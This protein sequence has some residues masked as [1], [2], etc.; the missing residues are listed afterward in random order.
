MAQKRN[1]DLE[2]VY[3]RL[4]DAPAG[5]HDL[6]APRAGLPVGAPLDLAELYI[7]IGGARLFHEAIEILPPDAVE[8]VEDAPHL[9]RFATLHGDDLACDKQARI[10]Q[11]DTAIDE[12]LQVASRLD[13]WLWGQLDAQAVVV[14]GEGEFA[15]DV[16][17]AEGELLPHIQH[18]M[19]RAQL[20][21]DA[22]ALAPRFWLGM[23][24][25]RG[26][27]TERGRAQLEDC[28]ARHERFHWGWHELAKI[29]EQL[30][31]FDNAYDEAVMAAEV[32]ERNQAACAGYLWGHVAKVA[33]LASKSAERDAAAQAVQRLAP[34]LRAEQLAGLRACISEGDRTSAQGLLALLRAV[35]PRDLDVLGLA[36]QVN[37]M[38]EE[39][40]VEEDATDDTDEDDGEPNE[41]EPASEP[42][43]VDTVAAGA[44]GH[45]TGKDG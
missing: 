45:G 35:W 34:N 19:W 13:R 42:A 20:K 18:G 29:S 44:G 26:G 25:A 24:L 32:A 22:D 21:R 4:T 15:E 9:W 38:P 10:Y 36:K 37:A 2:T 17:D 12:W 40:V 6:D 14:D 28:V 8:P 1:A 23:D 11:W 27:D 31:E 3:D 41:A 7:L 39:L 5:L 16:F 43:R 30:G 33:L